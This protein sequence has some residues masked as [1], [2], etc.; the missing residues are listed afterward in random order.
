MMWGFCAV[1][2]GDTVAQGVESSLLPAVYEVVLLD[3]SVSGGQMVPDVHDCE[4]IDLGHLRSAV[5]R[6]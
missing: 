1:Y 5:G 3:G 4:A 6:V 2:Q